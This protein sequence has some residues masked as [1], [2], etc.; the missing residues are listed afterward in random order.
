MSYNPNEKKILDEE[1]KEI[2]KA[3]P[4]GFSNQKSQTV[5][6]L[7]V[8][9][10][11]NSFFVGERANLII[12]APYEGK[13][14]PVDSISVYI[15]PDGKKPTQKYQNAPI[16]LVRD[17]GKV[18]T[19][20]N[21]DYFDYAKSI[22]IDW[23]KEKFVSTIHFVPNK[24]ISTAD[25]IVIIK[26]NVGFSKQWEIKDA[27]NVKQAIF[28][29]ILLENTDYNWAWKIAIKDSTESSFSQ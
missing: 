22:S 2:V 27:F 4:N 7:D 16:K 21:G 17:H 8:I 10:K 25:V 12:Q 19:L 26:N 18:F 15:F 13:L 6:N 14:V 24:E 3:Y 5:T 9:S 23:V 20:N 11:P 28:S 29:D 1:V